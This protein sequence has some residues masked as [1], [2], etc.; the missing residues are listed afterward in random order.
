MNTFA[1]VVFIFLVLWP[2]GS[3]AKK[4]KLIFDHEHGLWT[5]ILKEHVVERSTR[6]LFN[7]SKLKKNPLLLEKY[8]SNLS[9]VTR[10]DFLAM[11]KNE[12]LSFLINAYN[13]FLIK[14]V[15]D[16]YPIKSIQ[17]LDGAFS[18][19][20]SKKSFTLLGEE[21]S[22]DKLA[23]DWIEGKFTRPES[24]FALT[25]A[26]LGHP[27]LLKHAYTPR[28][29]REQLLL[30][31]KL[32]L[33]NHENNYFE[34]QTK[35]LWLSPVLNEYR[36]KLEKKGSNLKTVVASDVAGGPV[37]RKLILKKES[38]VKF[39]EYNWALNDFSEI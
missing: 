6:T 37:E 13:A 20:Q 1:K 24:L 35:T 11:K 17:E 14:M 31:K 29:L 8:L 7:Y 38:R 28:K 33:K 4:A 10:S 39:V 23:H 3:F 27:V 30:A 32:F 15:L 2:E 21:M 25:R 16:Q 5:D 36:L 9:A 22:L 12:Q 26:S 19:F 18:T 34:L